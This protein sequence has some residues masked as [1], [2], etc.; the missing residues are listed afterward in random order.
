[1]RAGLRPYLPATSSVRA[2]HQVLDDRV[3]A[4]RETGEPGG[5][6]KTKSDLLGHRRDPVVMECLFE[7]AAVERTEVGQLLH[8]EV[9]LLLG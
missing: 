7:G 8:R 3:I 4:L 5:K 2:E 6:V 1:M 9:T